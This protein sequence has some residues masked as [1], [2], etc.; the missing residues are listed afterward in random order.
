MGFPTALLE[1]SFEHFPREFFYQFYHEKL[2]EKKHY[3]F[4]RF[5]VEN[6][7]KYEKSWK[8]Q[9]AVVDPPL[10]WLPMA[11]VTISEFIYRAKN[12]LWFL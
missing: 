5:F 3:T 2:V 6:K 7:W 9:S 8:Q 11:S 4:D 12:R 1:G 10:I